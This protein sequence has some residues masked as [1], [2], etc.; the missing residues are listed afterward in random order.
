MAASTNYFLKRRIQTEDS[1][2]CYVLVYLTQ[3]DQ[4]AAC[5]YNFKANN[6][7][8]LLSK[9]TPAPD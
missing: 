3:V 2:V 6:R 1:L 9:F 4:R 7:F 5:V 8:L